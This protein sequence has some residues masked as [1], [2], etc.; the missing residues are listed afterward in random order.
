MRSMKAL[1]VGSA[2]LLACFSQGVHAQIKNSV[3]AEYNEAVRSGDS[4]RMRFAATALGEAALENA[5]DPQ[6]GLIGFEAAFRLCR[7]GQ[8]AEGQPFAAFAERQS[9]GEGLPPLDQR[10]LLLAF[11]EWKA[12]PGRSTR[13]QLD[14]LI[15]AQ[16]EGEVSTV[17]L[18]VFTRRMEHDA[19]KG[20]FE[21]LEDTAAWLSTHLSDERALVGELWS[22]A[23]LLRQVAAF[24][25]SASVD[26]AMGLAVLE[27]DLMM[28]PNVEIRAGRS[29]PDWWEKNYYTTQAWRMAMAAFFDSVNERR[30]DAAEANRI[31]EKTERLRDPAS[32][33]DNTAGDD[34]P[35]RS[36]SA[37]LI[38]KPA[39][40]YPG[41]ALRKGM[42]GALI[43]RFKADENGRI[44]EP[45]VLASVP[46][47]GFDDKVIETVS[48][49]HLDWSDEKNCRRESSNTILPFVFQLGR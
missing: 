41:K 39:M 37:D 35:L 40:R 46:Q 44:Y 1:T 17:S 3:V 32:R 31:A 20:D 43:I 47:G 25:T 29:V 21:S 42:F 13:E 8:C 45:E 33:F 15:E 2:L 5:D 22:T 38:Q 48:K 27:N 49:W 34:S 12:A 24:N 14:S 7:I 6:A 30:Y 28:L 18:F 19:T 16:A 4:S 23:E 26:A 10:A 11:A 36:C 9:V